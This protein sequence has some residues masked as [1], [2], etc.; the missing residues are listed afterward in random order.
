MAD[1]HPGSWDPAS[2]E[3]ITATIAHS[4]RFEGKR[5]V[6]DAERLANYALAERIYESLRRS[7]TITPTKDAKAI[8]GQ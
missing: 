4:L 8:L 2:P 7:Y 6:R 5:A 3:A 1:N